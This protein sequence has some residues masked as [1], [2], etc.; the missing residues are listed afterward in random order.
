MNLYTVRRS[1]QEE[2]REQ[3]EEEFV[4]AE[5]MHAVFNKL[6]SRRLRIVRIKELATDITVVKE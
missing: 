4:V 3:F 2:G 6:A 1:R 5:S